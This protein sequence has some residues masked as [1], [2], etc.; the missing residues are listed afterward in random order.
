MTQEQRLAQYVK[1]TLSPTSFLSASDAA[2]IG[3]ARDRPAAWG[4]GGE[5]YGKR[6]ASAF[7]EHYERE[8]MLFGLSSALHEDNRFVP[9]GDTRVSR[10]V[11]SAVASTFLARHDDGSRHF[12]FSR[13]IAFAGAAALS[14][15]WQPEH[16]RHV[17]GAIANFGTSISVAVGFNEA[18]EFLP[19]VFH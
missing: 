11:G 1:D 17:G 5:G 9:S 14:R 4:Q 6:Y 19:Q 3:Q 8:T 12:S 18:R 2:A 15:M 7:V 10:R 13:L 16:N